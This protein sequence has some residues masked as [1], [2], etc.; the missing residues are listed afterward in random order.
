MV[1]NCMQLR[2]RGPVL[3]LLYVHLNL[4]LKLFRRLPHRSAR[5]WVKHSLVK[6]RLEEQC[7]LETRHAGHTR[8]V[9][10]SGS[11]KNRNL[12]A[13]IREVRDQYD[14]KLADLEY[15]TDE[16]QARLAIYDRG[17]EAPC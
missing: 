4:S 15:E 2:Q 1:H 5:R 16:K 8:D 11:E 9:L 13:N 12:H 14:Q 6:S 7:G 3:R 10:D 17:S